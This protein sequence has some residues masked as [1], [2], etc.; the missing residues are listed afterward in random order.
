MSYLWGNGDPTSGSANPVNPN[1]G[2]TF[3]AGQAVQYIP[4][5]GPVANTSATVTIVNGSSITYHIV[6]N[7]DLGNTF[8]LAWDMTCA[9]D[10]IQGLV[11]L[12]STSLQPTPLP[13]ALPLF[14]G[15]LG[16]LGLFG[17]RRKQKIAAA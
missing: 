3:R 10:A 2:F 14:A 15:G 11:T 13:A 4:T 1:N 8:A 16:V 5:V 12:P 6:D 17:R 7:G 9:N